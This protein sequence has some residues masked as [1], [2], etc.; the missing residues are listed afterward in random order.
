MVTAAGTRKKEL[1]VPAK[2]G[3]RI[4]IIIRKGL[5]LKNKS[6]EIKQATEQ[7]NERLIPHAENLTAKTGLKSAVF[8]SEDGKVTVKFNESIMYDE[9]DMDHIKTVLGPVFTQMFHEIPS[10]AVNPEDIPEIKER[11]GHEFK[12]LVKVQK[13]HKHTKALLDL[14]SD[15]DN[16]VARELRNHISIEPRK[17]TISYETVTE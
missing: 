15:G 3:K 8:K 9:K 2:N 13:T 7:N 14:I 12:R 10:F 16:E 6:N 1:E 17:P 11:L 4:E 5:Y